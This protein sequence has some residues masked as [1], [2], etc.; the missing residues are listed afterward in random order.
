MNILLKD[1]I[2]KL[3]WSGH[4]EGVG[5]RGIDRHVGRPDDHLYTGHHEVADHPVYHLGDNCRGHRAINLVRAMN[6][7]STQA[8]LRYRPRL[9]ERGV[10]E[11]LCHR[12]L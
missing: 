7:G 12:D 6:K 10:H 5:H 2:I 1:R 4:G 11:A 8:R 9:H 3:T